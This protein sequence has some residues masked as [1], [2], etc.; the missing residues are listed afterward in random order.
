MEKWITIQK[1]EQILVTTCDICGLELKNRPQIGAARYS[2]AFEDGREVLGFH[3][4][5][6][7][8]KNLIETHG[9]YAKTDNHHLQ[10]KQETV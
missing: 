6:D 8:L 1:P 2:Y 5:D 10:T 7:C 9:Y 3:I 4:H